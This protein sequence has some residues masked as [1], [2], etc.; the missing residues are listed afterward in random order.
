[1]ETETDM[2]TA[3]QRLQ[4]LWAAGDY[5]RALKLAATWPRLGKDRDAIRSGWLAARDPRFLRQLGKNPDAVYAAGLTA[6]AERYR[7]P[8]PE[9]RA[10]LLSKKTRQADEAAIRACYSDEDCPRCRR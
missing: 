1:M 3:L 9:I 4:H 2:T 5:R 6:V 8:H 10:P 7:L